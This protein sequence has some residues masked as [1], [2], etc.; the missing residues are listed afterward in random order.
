MHYCVHLLTKELPT[1]K[2]IYEILKPYNYENFHSQEKD[3]ENIEYP[4]FT[5]DWYEIGGR[6]RSGFKL[7][8]DTDGNNDYKWR[9]IISK[10]K[11]RNNRLF[12][13]SLLSTLKKGFEEDWLYHEEDWFTSI[14]FWDGY[15][16]VDGGKQKDILNLED[17]GCYVCILPDGSAIS[18]CR[19]D[20]R[21]FIDDD[22]FDEKY[23]EALKE[24]MDGFITILDI[25]D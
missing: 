16:Y 3:D 11:E 9:Y 21:Q 25:H 5:W 15:I 19:W 14:G 23:Q 17:A 24:N 4:P 12:I 13:S 18:R 6:Y 10:D 22:K 2:Q 1:E 8:V 20:G 7:K